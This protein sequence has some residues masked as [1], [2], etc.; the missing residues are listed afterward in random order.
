MRTVT[1][2]A[3]I[4]VRE[5]RIKEGYSL[6]ELDHKSGVAGSTIGDWE[7]GRCA[8][9]VQALENVLRVLGHDLEVVPRLS[10]NVRDSH[11]DNH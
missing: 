10:Q 2:W 11:P 8:P 1:H 6:L 3:A 5:L 7:R 9:G 4:Q